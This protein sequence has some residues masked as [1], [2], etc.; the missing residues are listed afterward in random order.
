MGVQV[1]MNWA[2]QGM[3]SYLDRLVLRSR[4][5]KL[6]FYLFQRVPLLGTYCLG[7]RNTFSHIC[8]LAFDIFGRKQP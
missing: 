6:R 4:F 1:A 8:R 5:E 7:Q 2:V 3:Q